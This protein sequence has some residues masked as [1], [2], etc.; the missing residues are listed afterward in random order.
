MK[1]REALK[2]IGIGFGTIVLTPSAVA[3][4]QKCQRNPDY[5]PV[6]FLDGKFEVLSELMELILPETKPPAD[7]DFPNPIESIPGAKELKLPEFVDS[8][9]HGVLPQ[10]ELDEVLKGFDAFIAQTLTDSTKESIQEINEEDLDNQL[11]KHLD[12]QPDHI[13]PEDMEP[14]QRFAHQLRSISVEAFKTNEYIGEQILAYSPIPGRHV[15]CI[16]LKEATGGRAW[17]L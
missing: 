14:A 2:N 10:E 1:R 12:S 7:L 16:D 6:T 4:L 9:V 3:L 11:K 15:G 8:Y 17:S 5:L 13:L